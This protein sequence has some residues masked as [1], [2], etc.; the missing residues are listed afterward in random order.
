MKVNVSF[1]GLYLWEL[2][3]TCDFEW[4]LVTRRR[5]FQWPLVSPY[6][7]LLH[8]PLSHLYVLIIECVVLFLEISAVDPTVLGLTARFQFSSSY[9]VIACCGP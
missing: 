9:V 2:F 8:A 7:T 1:F 5:K 3:Q 6:L 4:S